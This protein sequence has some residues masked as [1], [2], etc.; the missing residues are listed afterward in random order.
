MSK[1]RLEA[2]S[3]GVIAIL[4]TIMMFEIRMPLGSDADALLSLMPVF[5]TYLL[6]FVFLGIYWSNHHHMLHVVRKID[7]FVLLANTHLL[8]WLSLLPLTTKW[9]NTSGFGGLPTAV[10]G[11]NCLLAAC[12][13]K[14]LQTT[15]IRADGPR[16][17]LREAVGADW[18]GLASLLIYSLAAL[19]AFRKPMAALALYLVVS[20]MWLPPDTRIESK[21]GTGGN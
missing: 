16:S 4:I 8:F 13:Y 1:H 7:G 9:L 3:D 10:Y 20:L 21:F 6:S 19:V 18:K 11:V 14:I 17:Q 5:L 2:F 15:L 12:A